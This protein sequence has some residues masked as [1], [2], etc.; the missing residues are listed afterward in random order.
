MGTTLLPTVGL[1]PEPLPCL[2]RF[3]YLAYPPRADWFG[4]ATWVEPMRR[5]WLVLRLTGTWLLLAPGMSNDVG[6]ANPDRPLHSVGQ[7]VLGEGWGCA[8]LQNRF[9]CWESIPPEAR[10]RGRRDTLPTWRAQLGGT[11]PGVDR[12]CS[13]EGD[14]L[15]CWHRPRR[16]EAAPRPWQG[17]GSFSKPRVAIPMRAID[18]ELLPGMVGGTFAC[19]SWDTDLWC[20]GDNTY[21]QLGS[22]DGPTDTARLL[23]IGGVTNVG[24]GTWHACV[25]Q[26]EPQLGENALYCWGRNDA[27]QLGIK[28][29][30]VCRVADGEVPC[31]KTPQ[32]VPFRLGLH[33]LM[34]ARNWGPGELRAGDLFTCSHHRAGIV[35]WGASR[36]GVFGRADLCPEDLRRSWPTRHGLV[37]APSATCSPTP[38]AIPGSDRFKSNFGIPRHRGPSPDPT[39]VTTK[40]AI[41]PRGICMVSD[42]GEIWCRG[43]IPSPRNLVAEQ[44]AVSPGDD[45]SACALTKNGRLYCWGEGY[46]PAGVPDRPLRIELGELPRPE[47]TTPTFQSTE[48]RT[49]QPWGRTCAVPHACGDSRRSLIPCASTAAARTWSEISASGDQFVGQVVSATGPLVVGST[50]LGCPDFDPVA[51]KAITVMP[52]CHVGGGPIMIA[53]SDSPLVLSC[54]DEPFQTYTGGFAGGQSVIATGLLSRATDDHG[55]TWKLSGDI[56]VCLKTPVEKGHPRDPR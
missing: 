56:A 36:D 14:L 51:G 15:R 24:F 34:L 22:G 38:V 27:G 21:G 4:M 2:P 48:T 29:P 44:V 47:K 19:V 23:N 13:L 37:P 26:Q 45:A 50:F 52:C 30:D 7:V 1:K 9:G 32:R 12:T 54:T 11:V 46:S 33:G 53:G 28:G 31:A 5:Q 20:A 41:G 40:Y 17:T 25:S 35:C 6:A 8:W 39:E 16:G 49:G 42:A 43:A 55:T 10:Q 18:K 3:P